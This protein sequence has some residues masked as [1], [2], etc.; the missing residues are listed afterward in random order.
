MYPYLRHVIPGVRLAVAKALHTFVT[1]PNL[2]RD[3]WMFDHFFSLLF[4]NL[5]LE[6]R[7]DIREL[8]FAAFQSGVQ[9]VESLSGG[10]ADVVGGS[11]EEWYEIIMTPIGTKLDDNLFVKGGKARSGYNVDKAMMAGDLSLISSDSMLETRIAGAKALAILRK[12]E[13]EDVSPISTTCADV[14]DFDVEL[15]QRYLK[16]TSAHQIFLASV[17]VQE[18]AKDVG[19]QSDGEPV[20]LGRT[21]EM[22][23]EIAQTLVQLVEA[24]PKST[25]REMTTLLRQVQAECQGLLGAFVSEGRVPKEKIPTIPSQ[26]DPT[27]KSAKAF[28]LDTAQS[29]IGPH[30]DALSKL[31]S[32]QMAPKA[33]PGLTTRQRKVMASLGYFMVMKERYDVQVSTA[34]CGALI[35]LRVMPSKFGPV[36]KSVMDGVKV[37]RQGDICIVLTVAER[38]ERDPANKSGRQRGGFRG[39]LQLA[40]VQWKEQSKR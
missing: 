28:S 25:Y 24:P 13:I 21:S 16:S 34:V 23:E 7:K 39:L 12:Y 8:T 35:A 40:F 32:K 19:S 27:G 18:W 38:R 6:Q 33:L 2:P 37:S 29:V 15:I 30:F 11:M 20:S 31:L 36:V 9:E 3:D 17:I 4:Q 5:I 26:I 1:V 22:G 10:L 14:Q